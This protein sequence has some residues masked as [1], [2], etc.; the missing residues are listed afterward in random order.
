[1]TIDEK[2]F[3][4]TLKRISNELALGSGRTEDFCL[5][6]IRGWVA[7]ELISKRFSNE[8]MDNFVDNE[9][10]EKQLDVLEQKWGRIL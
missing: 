1:M 7:A 2:W 6:M 3:I 4:K 9:G 8:L 5:G 10:L